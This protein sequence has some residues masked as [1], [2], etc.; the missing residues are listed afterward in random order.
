MQVSCKSI[1]FHSSSDI[2]LKVV[3]FPDS[4]QQIVDF[5]GYLYPAVK[6]LKLQIKIL[7]C[8]PPFVKKNN[9][10]HLMIKISY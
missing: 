7:F 9:I 2:F 4:S 3:K 6:G 10:S 1:H 5:S 8:Y